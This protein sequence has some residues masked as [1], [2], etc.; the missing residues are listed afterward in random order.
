VHSPKTTGVLLLAVG[1]ATAGLTLSRPAH[2]AAPPDQ[3]AAHAAAPAP[4]SQVTHVTQARRLLA[5]PESARD[6][7]GGGRPT[8]R[9][10]AQPVNPAPSRN[11]DKGGKASPAASPRQP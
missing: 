7:P 2:D 8:R 1:V 4:L 10:A 9:G 6:R 11:R 3:P 5:H